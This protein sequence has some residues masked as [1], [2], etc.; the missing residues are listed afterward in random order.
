LRLLGIFIVVFGVTAGAHATEESPYRTVVTAAP[1]A[2]EEREHGRSVTVINAAQIEKKR[3]E[4][5]SD[6]LREVPGIHVAASGGAGSL[7][8]LFIRGGKGGHALVL[9]DDMPL[10]DPFSVENAADLSDILTDGVSRIEI[11]RGPHAVVYGPGA[12]SGVVRISTTPAAG[13][14]PL[15]LF[16]EMGLVDLDPHDVAVNHLRLG[17]AL[18]GTTGQG[19]YRFEASFRDT[20]GYSAAGEHYGNTEEDRAR[21]LTLAGR[22]VVRPTEGIV[23]ST[24]VRRIT[25][26]TDIDN[27]PGPFR[28]DPNHIFASERLLARFAADITSFGGAWR[29][30]AALTLTRHTADDRNEPDSRYDERGFTRAFFIGETVEAAW[31]NHLTVLPRQHLEAGIVLNGGL[32]A[33]DWE[34][35]RATPVMLGVLPRRGTFTTGLY[36]LDTIA[37]VEDLSLSV[38]GRG[39]LFLYRRHGMTTDPAGNPLLTP[40]HFV[41]TAHGTYSA[42]AAYRI[43]LSDTTLRASVASAF[44]PPPLFQLYSAYGSEFLKAEETLALDGGIEQ[45]FWERRLLIE[46]TGFYQETRNAIE[47]SYGC[48]GTLCGR[49]QNRGWL[50]AAGIETAVALRPHRTFTLNGAYTFTATDAFDIVRY[51]G[52]RWRDSRPVLRRPAH[53]AHL[54]L[55][56]SP[57]RRFDAN[58]G[59]TLLGARRDI[60]YRYPYEPRTVTLP[61]ALIGSLAVSV[62]PLPRVRFYGRIENLFDSDYEVVKGFGTPGISLYLGMTLDVGGG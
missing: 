5:V 27:G 40:E 45:R 21:T 39:D 3:K 25:A 26:D 58:L 50:T 52:R 44:K 55:D 34:M 11:L 6:L 10:N 8:T 59:L 30:E 56:W 33:A 23:L 9:L 14:P 15:S 35:D 47:F 37:P 13:A 61:P 31:R 2:V 62:R 57:D 60:E 32:G 4:Q 24:T 51:D 16:S 29:Q 53:L 7:T 46:A 1:D 17:G 22:F 48:D 38:G 49:Y 12:M 41:A 36:V 18:G 54:W 28:D 20:G 43:A 42:A 19:N